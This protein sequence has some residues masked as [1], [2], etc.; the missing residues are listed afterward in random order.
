MFIEKNITPYIIFAEDSI[1]NALKKITD[2]KRRIIFSVTESGV[3]EGILTD[4]DIRD[5]LISQDSIDLDQS[6]SRVSNKAFQYVRT[7]DEH[8]K[9]HSKFSEKI[10]AIPILNEYDR[11][12]SIAWRRTSQIRI[13]SYLI[14]ETSPIFVIA[15]IGNNHNGDK[16]LAKKLIDEAVGA[17]ANCAKF[18]MRDLNSLYNNKGNPDDDREDLGSQYI[19]DLLSKFQLQ[20]DEMFEMF[21]YCMQQ[22][23]L[24]LCTPWDLNSLNLL[25]QF[26]MEAYKVASADLTN[27]ELLSKLI[28]IK[29]P[30]ICSTGMSSEEEINETITLLKRHGAIYILLHCNSTYPAP[31]KDINLNYIKRLQ[32]IGDCPVGYSGH[33]RGIHIPIAAVSMGAKLIEKHLT[34]DKSLEGNDHKVSLLPEEFKSMV[35]CIR[36]LEQALGKNNERFISQG[37]LINREA[38]AKSLIINR[39]LEIG[40]TITSNMIEV[41]SPGKGL[42]P[43]RKKELVGTKAK[44]LMNAGDF[45]YPSDLQSDQIQARPYRFKRKW[46]LPVRYHD[47]KDLLNKSNPDLL[48]I[49]LSYKDLDQNVSKYFEDEYDLDLIVHSP[50]LFEKDHILDLCSIDQN[51]RQIS[52]Q[53]MQR[54]INVT[55]ELKKYFLRATCPLI[56]TNIGGFSSSA[57]LPTFERKKL[58]KILLNSFAQLDSS[59]IEIIPQTMPPFPWHMGGQQF[60]N[61]FIEPAEI[62]EFCESENFRICFDVSH[63]KLACNNLQY[64]F[65][66]FVESVGKV[67]A[68]LHLADAKGVDGEGLQIGDG[69]ID[70]LALSAALETQAPNAS[71]IPEVWQG[72]KNEGEGFWVSLENLEKWF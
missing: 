13:G 60:H 71:F 64:S 56:V 55:R 5:W 43:N 49:H 67:T 32:E 66:S 25:E 17:G 58:Y 33:E 3:L 19:L 57:P 11:L 30:L 42:Q 15:E 68:H 46:G 9:I 61:L 4:G 44:R 36:D 14:G 70:F 51:Y 40:K 8:E 53:K 38:L 24:P 62:V 41:K 65:Q 29:K 18:Q 26:G 59:G 45:F 27:H 52:I 12:T 39:N 16:D 37:E 6:V 31:F 50:E 54:V 21:D 1:L 23:I 10:E 2:N 72:H 63:S 7:K 20:P 69:E 47:F 35:D 28:D 34:L 48:E 22:G